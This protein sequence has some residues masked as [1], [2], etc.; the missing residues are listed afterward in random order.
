MSRVYLSTECIQSEWV[1][2]W[3]EMLKSSALHYT[4]LHGM[5]KNINYTVY[6]LLQTLCKTLSIIYH[7][8]LYDEFIH[9]A[10]GYNVLHANGFAS[11]EEHVYKY[12]EHMYKYA[13][14]SPFIINQVDTLKQI[15]SLQQLSIEKNI[16]YPSDSIMERV[17][18]ASFYTNQ[19]TNGG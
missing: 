17:S 18:L 4:H 5:P 16:T 12:A 10:D 15:Y 13:E 6:D 8:S 1:N 11:Q 3:K 2:E 14:H 9:A 19:R 7:P